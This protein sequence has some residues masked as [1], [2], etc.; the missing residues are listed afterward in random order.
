MSFEQIKARIAMMLE[1]STYQPEDLHEM[2]EVLREQVA[3][4]RAQNLTVPDDLLDLEKRLD[5]AFSK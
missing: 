2:R 1:E 5:E 4:L 3:D